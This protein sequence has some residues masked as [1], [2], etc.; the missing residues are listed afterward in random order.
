MDPAVP[1]P[2]PSQSRRDR[3][4]GKLRE[5]KELRQRILQPIPER[6]RWLKLI[7]TGY[8]AYHAV[9]KSRGEPLFNFHSL[10]RFTASGSIGLGFSRMRL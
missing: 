3:R 2:N 8:Y 10:R 9:P 1:G 5:I 6:G 4:W 7:L